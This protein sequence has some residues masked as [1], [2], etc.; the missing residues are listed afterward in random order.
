MRTQNNKLL[1]ENV[2]NGKQR[3]KRTGGNHMRGLKMRTLVSALVAATVPIF[4]IGQALATPE[5]QVF[6]APGVELAVKP[7]QT[8]NNDFEFKQ[9]QTRKSAFQRRQEAI[10]RI[11]ALK[12]GQPIP[13]PS[14]PVITPK[15]TPPPGAPPPPP[16]TSVQP[17]VG[18]GI[19]RA[20]DVNIPNFANSPN[21]RKFVNGLPGLGSGAANNLGQY[22]PVA[23]PDTTNYPGSDYYEIAVVEYTEQLHSDLPPTK[24]RGYV[25]Q[26]GGDPNPHYLGPVIVAMKDRPVRIKF[27]NLLPTGAGGDLFLPVDTTLMGAGMGPLGMNVTPGNPMIYT[28]NR[29]TL[30]LHGGR[31]PWISDGT[32][33]QWTVPNREATD[34]KKGVATVNVPDMP[35]AGP[36]EMTFYWP[37]GQSARLMFY[38][39]HAYGI[40]RLNVYAG[41]AAGYVITDAIEQDLITRGILPGLGVPLVIQDKSF[42]NDAATSLATSTNLPPGYAPTPLTDTV[43]PLWSAYVPG[44]T[45]GGNLWLPHEYMPNE[46]PFDPR[47]YNDFGRWDYGP[48][49]NPPMVVNN[50]ELPSPTIVPEAFGDT[51]MVNGTAFPYVELPPTAVRLRILNACNDRMLNL[52]LYKAEPLTIRLVNGGANYVD[53]IVTLSGGGATVQGEAIAT[54]VDPL[55]GV[56][57]AI[58]VTSTGAGYTGAPTVTI[59]DNGGTGSG[60]VAF[61]S[62]NTEVHM[63]PALANPAYPTWPQD[64]RPGGV[65]DPTTKGPDLYQIGNEGGFLAD[66]AV[67]SPQPVD[68]DYNRRSV[69]MG[70]VTSKA[71]YVPTAVRADVVVDLSGAQDGDTYIL[72][73]DAPAPMPL[74]DSRYDYFTDDPD[75]TAIGG[76]PTTAPGF[77]PNTR[78]IMQIRIKGTPSAPYNLAAL[79][80]ALPAAFVA[81]QEAFIVPPA[82]YANSLDETMNLTG[83]SQSVAQVKAVVGGQ[84]YT[85]PPNVTFF[86]GGGAGAA[87]K[88][89]LNGVVGIAL[90]TSGSG[91]TANPTIAIAAVAP[92]VGAG[93]T[94]FAQVSGGVITGIT[95]DNPGSNY[96]VAPNVTI[97]DPTGLGA[98]ATANIT[99]GSVGTIVVTKGGSNYVKAPYAYLTGGGGSGAQANALLTGA[100]VLDGKN[101]VEGMDM[102]FG[103]MNAVLGST[104]NPLTPLVGLGPV[105]GAAFYVDPPTEILTPEK[106]LLWR[107]THIGVDSHA[108]HFHLFDVQV[109]NRVDWTGVVKPPTLGEMGW[110]ETVETD[111][112]TDVVLALRPTAAAMKLPFGLP[113]SSRLLDVTMPAGST[114]NFT[115]VAPPAGVPAAAQLFNFTN[116]F[117]WEYV[118]HCHLLGHEEND[119]MRPIVFDVPAAV[120]TAP[121]L[122]AAVT[123]GIK[124]TWTDPTPFNYT[125]G[126]PT[127]TLGNP[128]NEVGFRI[129]RATLS[130]T[131]TPGTYTVVTNILANKTNHTD[132]LPDSGA[133]SYRVVAYN[134]AGQSVSIPV[135]V[136][137]TCPPPTAPTALAGVVQSGPR[138]A[139]TWRDNATTET[140][141]VLER[142]DVIAGVTNAFF[143]IAAVAPLAATG[144]VTYN[145]AL[146]VA[147]SNYVYRVKASNN[148]AYSAPATSA[149][150]AVPLPVAP[151][152]LTATLLTGVQVRLSWTD[153]DTLETGFVIERADVTNAVVGPFAQI[154]T[155]AARAGT[156]AVT[157]TNT[158]GVFG[159]NYVFRVK[160]M[161]G[162]I[163]SAYATSGQVSMPTPPAAPSG[164]IS[165]AALQGANAIVM[166]AWT[167]NATNETGFAIQR[168]SNVGFTTGL[169]T[170]PVAANSTSWL[171]GNLARATTFWFRVAATNAVGSSAWITNSIRTP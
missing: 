77:G 151:T 24:L 50:T 101:I 139:L 122:S 144:N 68:F 119:M 154:A 31:T 171:S 132:V 96:L 75:Q 7:A 125:T 145:D 2:V 150:I 118:W 82:T 121:R 157:I 23:V 35:P 92:D 86:G 15:V 61:A 48:W 60:A 52:Q 85:T 55:T 83:K 40:T 143:Q 65:P 69:T 5:G 142:A 70:S 28:Q 56:I 78:T 14:V 120:P 107:L 11:E 88:A 94:A 45:V 164:L 3:P 158:T 123:T 124:L 162:I 113:R 104:P 99:L 53:P 168:A 147:G 155:Q 54:V 33:H 127:N 152:G 166:L 76:A 140:G 10:Q 135:A 37:N 165:A 51:M 161:S 17:P 109:V 100:T 149:R 34:Y 93:A 4:T 137:P 115:P 128:M 21:L 95:V 42:V 167:D 133:R 163:G 116:D 108:V 126:L 8:N 159:S 26:N 12:N 72:Y 49:M 41:E 129:E 136:C 97:T 38:H 18:M 79:Q 156:G 44:G 131:G 91:Y 22:I 43:D 71:L 59:T 110:K 134:A 111:P 80:A 105:I 16:P 90:V 153:N 89:T 138:I 32:P 13:E 112:F 117:G 84:N 102:E 1:N 30:H 106:P 66:V 25:Q 146:V 27:K 74:Y 160:T 64:G 63:V 67:L 169:V 20:V 148:G 36:G 81:G 98:T 6:A 9:A 57:T 141:F 130:A 103:R 73:N 114:A 62:A 87:A 46:N 170:T 29:A 19:N 58:T 47:G 39:D